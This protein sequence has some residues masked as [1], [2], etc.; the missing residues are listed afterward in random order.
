MGHPFPTPFACVLAVAGAWALGACGSDDSGFAVGAALQVEVAPTVV[1]FPATGLGEVSVRSITVRH[2][3][4]DGVLE[5]RDVWL[6]TESAEL[7]LD[8]PSSQDLEP[9][10][11]ATWTIT[12]VPEG[13]KATTSHLRMNHNVVD[14]GPIQIRITTQG[15]DGQLALGAELIDF[16]PVLAGDS[17]TASVTVRNVGVDDLVVTGLFMEPGASEDFDIVWTTAPTGVLKAGASRDLF[18]TYEPTGQDWDAGRIRVEATG[19]VPQTTVW[20][21]GHE[22]GPILHFAPAVVAFGPVALGAEQVRSLNIANLGNRDLLLDSIEPAPDSAPGLATDAGGAEWPLLLEPGWDIW[23]DVTYAPMSLGEAS[24]G[25]LGSLRIVSN[26][27]LRSPTVVPV[28][29]QS[30]APV[31]T[32][33]PDE[34]D[35]GYV[36]T[37]ITA[38]RQV[39]LV[40]DGALPLEVYSVQVTSPQNGEMAVEIDPGFAPTFDIPGPGAVAPWSATAVT[41]TFSNKGTIDPVV[42]GMLRIESNDPERPVWF[43]DMVGRRGGDPT[44]APAFVPMLTYFGGVAHQTSKTLDVHLVNKGTGECT[45]QDAWIA[46]CT[47]DGILEVCDDAMASPTFF[48]DGAVPL[49]LVMGPGA[50]SSI[51]VRFDAPTFLGGSESGI[52]SY[53]ALLRAKVTDPYTGGDVLVPWVG[54]GFALPNLRGDSGIPHLDIYPDAVDHGFVALGCK[55]PST[56]VSLLSGGPVPVTVEKVVWDVCSSEFYVDGM[57][58]LPHAIETGAG[59]GLAPTYLAANLGPQSCAFHIHSTDP[60]Q[61]VQTVELSAIGV[62]ETVIT[63]TFD[64]KSVQEV[65][66]LFVVDDSGSMSEEQSNLANNFTAF[67]EAAT[68]WETDYR[69]GVTTTDMYTVQGALQGSPPVV[70]PADGEDAFVNNVLVGTG[71]SGFEEGL[72]GAKAS[73]D[74]A[75]APY[76]REEAVLVV[77]FV[78]DEEDQSPGQPLDFLNDFQFIKQGSPD[79]FRAYAIVGDPGGCSSASGNADAGLRYIKVAEQ[80]GGGWA[81]ICDSSFADALQSFGEN[82]FGP[83]SH[84]PLGGY[85]K[86]GTVTVLVNGVPCEEGWQYDPAQKTVV[87][88]DD[89][90]CMPTNGDFVSVT[91]ELDCY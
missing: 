10:A 83:K 54:G 25:S 40:N 75:F 62:E 42:W 63:E 73:L 22:V 49:G 30:G 3:G 29:G 89:A 58:D 86:A 84:F 53:A 69:I 27:V 5:L 26:D 76:L 37:G 45:L 61:P 11:A 55:S 18:V 81:S 47:K 64:G 31:L 70:T 41:V 7:T 1:D 39:T 50:A 78:S 68:V 65:D 12:F 19:Q 56:L 91:Y 88:A 16:G 72:A 4:S 17:A 9:G 66:V 80:S 38:A 44:C 59:V 74:G 23:L 82:S 57:P 48:F 24:S 33:V 21:E 32:V 46:H 51:P 15:Q 85:A 8:G 90:P 6:D 43:V 34:V 13:S 14:L 52:A 28:A 20:L 71:G 79:L 67:I 36:G 87:F 60:D 77:I 2:V 35:F